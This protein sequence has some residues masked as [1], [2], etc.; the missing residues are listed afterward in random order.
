[1]DNSESSNSPVASLEISA[2][3]NEATSAPDWFL[4]CAEAMNEPAERRISSWLAAP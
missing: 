4:V 2:K 3:V 1:V